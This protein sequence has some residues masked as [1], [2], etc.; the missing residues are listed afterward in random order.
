M[1]QSKPKKIALIVEGGGMRGVFA[2]G[3]LDSFI[4]MNFSPFTLYIGVSAGSSNL[5]SHLAGHKGRNYR[6]IMSCA[7]SGQFINRWKFLKGGHYL[8]LDW[9]QSECLEMHPLDEQAAFQRLKSTGSQFLVVC[10]N[11]ETGKPI[12]CQP[13]IKTLHNILLGSC[14]VPLLYR[15]PVYIDDTRVIDGSVSDPLPIQKAYEQGATDIV[16]I[17]SRE[18]SYRK[19]EGGLEAKVSSYV[20]RDYPN[21]QA[22]I[23]NQPKTYNESVEFIEHPPTD[24]RVYQIASHTPLSTT[25]TTTNTDTLEVDYRL[26]QQLGE[27]F[28]HQYKHNFEQAIEPVDIDAEVDIA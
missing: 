26:G 14:S 18:K 7:T 16:V 24:T 25:R 1:T 2:A 19:S 13:N 15:S 8:D 6:V 22:T 11:M 23:D 17:R 3:V 5:I 21:M 4:E 12:Y 9:F 10:T 20:Y 27:E 28:I